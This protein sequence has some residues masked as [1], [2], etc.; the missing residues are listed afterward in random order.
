MKA[1]N[2]FKEK[3]NKILSG[4]MFLIVLHFYGCMPASQFQYLSAKYTGR[5]EAAATVMVMPFVP[6]SYSP[7]QKDNFIEKKNKQQKSITKT[8]IEFFE[9]YIPQLLSENS[10]AKILRFENIGSTSKLKYEIQQTENETGKKFDLPIPA[11]NKDI[12]KSA[13]PDYL[14][15]FTDLYFSKGSN[16]QGVALGQG[17]KTVFSLDAGL[18]YVLWDNK[19]SIVVGFGNLSYSQRLLDIPQREDYLMVLGKFAA[20]IIE[21]SP[22]QLKKTYL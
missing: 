6:N 9:N 1:K 15:L 20:D 17:S 18:E 4:I 5:N 22:F 10:E 3:M 2:I 8:E 11:F 13:I 21:K 7:V 16:E 14:I 12:F 19:K